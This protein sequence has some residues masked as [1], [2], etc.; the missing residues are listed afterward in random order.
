MR[1]TDHI[2][3]KTKT[4]IYSI[5]FFCFT[6]TTINYLRHFCHEK[7]QCCSSPYLP[8]SQCDG[9]TD[10]SLSTRKACHLYQ[11]TNSVTPASPASPDSSARRWLQLHF[12]PLLTVGAG[13]DERER[14]RGGKLWPDKT[15]QLFVVRTLLSAH[16]ADSASLVSTGTTVSCTI[17]SDN[18]LP[19][20][21]RGEYFQY[22][23][24][25]R[26]SLYPDSVGRP[27][28][29]PRAP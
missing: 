11:K 15:Y 23:P 19:P 21:T 10:C 9:V 24:E 2:R 12:I 18:L 16:T 7:V 27:R 25:Q 1:D 17:I 28:P 5:I 22:I 8:L 6:L 3:K 13:R 26:K 4:T 14:E 20:E 29:R